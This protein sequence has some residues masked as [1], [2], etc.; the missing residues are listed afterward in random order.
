MKAL[1]KV[2][3][4]PKYTAI[5]PNMIRLKRASWSSFKQA[6]KQRRRIIIMRIWRQNILKKGVFNSNGLSL[7]LVSIYSVV[8][9]KF[10]IAIQSLRVRSSSGLS[11]Y[12]LLSLLYSTTTLTLEENGLRVSSPVQVCKYSSSGVFSG[13]SFKLFI[14]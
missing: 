13:T 2:T 6:A 7:I 9:K 8:L 4:L 3:T 5:M 1:I 12:L 14:T 11:K 10:S